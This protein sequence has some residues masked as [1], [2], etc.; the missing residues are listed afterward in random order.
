VAI[1]A[2]SCSSSRPASRSSGTGR[3]DNITRAPEAVS[4]AGQAAGMKLYLSRYA[5]NVRTFMPASRIGS[6]ILE[7]QP[8]RTVM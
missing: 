6:K 7:L 1:S 5:R 2:L 3:I 4:F 8:R